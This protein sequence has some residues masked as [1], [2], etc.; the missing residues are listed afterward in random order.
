[1]EILLVLGDWSA[2][3]HGKTENI[4]V[5]STLNRKELEEAY[6]AG[7]EILNID[8]SEECC[9]DYEDGSIEK[10][11]FN[12]FLELN[13]SLPDFDGWGCNDDDRDD[14]C[15]S[16]SNEQFAAM[17]MITCK[18]GNPSLVWTFSE[19]NETSINIG[20]YGLMGS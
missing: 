3:G 1:M 11:I 2:D 17:Y 12:K 13:P 5:N 6:K 8:V 18:V 14:G 7:A 16:I 20:G 15:I 10:E 4:I 19:V 9:A